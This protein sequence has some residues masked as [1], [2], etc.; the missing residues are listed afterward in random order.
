MRRIYYTAIPLQSNFVL[1]SAVPEAVNFR[2]LDQTPRR[3]PILRIL[4]QTME[5]GDEA[6]LIVVR[7]SNSKENP[8][9]AAFLQELESLQIPN[10]RVRDLVLEES[11]SRDVILSMFKSLVG[12]LQNHACYYACITFGT[13][14]W[15]LVLQSVMNYAKK[16]LPDTEVKGIYYQEALRENG[17][18]VKHRI[19][20]MSVLQSL[21]NVVDLV[22]ATEGENPEAAIDLLLEGL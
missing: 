1:Q 3:F 16:V 5:P 20:D 12:T 15:P 19:Y 14:L 10:V 6:D 13:K 2:L 22:A 17:Q 11:Q 7:Q 18:I 8:N 21:N 4:A 9:Y